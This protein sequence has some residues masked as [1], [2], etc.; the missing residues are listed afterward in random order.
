MARASFASWMM[1]G[2]F[3]IN[4]LDVTPVLY[5]QRDGIMDLFGYER[6]HL[7]ACFVVLLC[8]GIFWRTLAFLAI[9]FANAKQRR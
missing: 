8:M 6:S 7:T 9:H 1:E 3:L 5:A 4:T 2:L